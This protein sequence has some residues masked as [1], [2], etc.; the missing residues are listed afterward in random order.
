MLLTM[1]L[2]CII[3][4]NI[5]N[6]V[7]RSICNVVKEEHCEYNFNCFVP[8]FQFRNTIMNIPNGDYNGTK[9]NIIIDR[10]SEFT[11]L[12]TMFLP[13][14]LPLASCVTVTCALFFQ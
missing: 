2:P 6:V 9:R 4:N 14:T 8:M 13:V 7:T 12:I 3:V 1:F 11:I 10:V 5:L